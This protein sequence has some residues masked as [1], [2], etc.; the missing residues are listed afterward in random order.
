MVAIASLR[1]LSD[2]AEIAENQLRAWESWQTVFDE[3]L[4]FGE[5][6]AQLASPKTVFVESEDF[7]KISAILTAAGYSE[8]YACVLNADIIVRP[9]LA[10]ALHEVVARGGRCAMSSRVNFGP[11]AAPDFGLDFFMAEPEI[12]TAA[13]K[14]VPPFYRIGHNSW[15]N[16]VLSYLNCRYG[17][18]FWDI[19][20]R[21]CIWHPVH[22][23]RKRVY[24]FTPVDDI[25]TL[26]CSLP[27]LRLV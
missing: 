4:Y 3:I 2:C 6:E 15:D 9:Q 27:K 24:A 8:D 25:Y 5:A 1:K 21:R 23:N 14:K 20:A 17:Q 22:G 18:W 7:P 11:G 12:W 26:H 13:A 19:S 16:W 10:D